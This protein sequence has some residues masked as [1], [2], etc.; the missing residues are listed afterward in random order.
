MT[1]GSVP[2]LDRPGNGSA[3]PEA[4]GAL[5]LVVE[6]DDAVGTQLVRGLRRAGYAARRVATATAA[7]MAVGGDEPPDVVLLDLGLPD[8]DGTEVCRRIRELGDIPVIVVTARA[9]E[10][11]RV[12][13]LDLGG[14]DYLVKPFGFEELLARIRAVRRRF[15]R[16]AALA[17]AAR[18]DAVRAA[19]AAGAANGHAGTAH[20]ASNRTGGHATE[21][22]V[23]GEGARGAAGAESRGAGDVVRHGGLLVDRRTR[24]IELDGRRLA[25]TARE[26]DLLA[27]L[28]ADPGRVRTRREIFQAVWG[29]WFGSTKVLD[30]HVGSLRRKLGRP[31]LIETVYGVG[32]RLADPA[33]EPGRAGGAR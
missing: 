4:D 10:S 22:A 20:G 17:D 19:G 8:L 13:A 11:D 25:I 9:D 6:D 24:R 18:A 27:F 29:P 33:V 31:E 15:A 7:L 23:A 2:R 1:A 5:V 21:A 32:F 3:A 16:V 28:A 14:D 26:F 12:E 30:V